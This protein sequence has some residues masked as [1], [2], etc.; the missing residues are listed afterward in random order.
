M[1]Y[2]YYRE[3]EERETSPYLSYVNSGMT[4]RQRVGTTTMFQHML[5]SNND[6]LKQEL[7]VRKR[8]KTREMQNNWAKV[9]M[10]VIC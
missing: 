10:S 8:C 9:L 5:L 6:T 2:V 7:S 4:G 3:R 1:C